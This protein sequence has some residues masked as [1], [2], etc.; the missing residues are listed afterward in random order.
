[1][2]KMVFGKAK[3]FKK[4]WIVYFLLFILLYFCELMIPKVLSQFIDSITQRHARF[5]LEKYIGIMVLLTLIL[6]ISS[7]YQRKASSKI[8]LK[9][10]H[11]LL[12]EV[13]AVLEQKNYLEV[14][15]MNPSYLNNRLFNDIITVVEFT[16]ND[17]MTAMIKI[18]ST[19]VIILWIAFIQY[20][21]LFIVLFAMLINIIGIFT[22]NKLVYER[23]YQYREI[24]NQYH[25]ENFERLA[26]I[27]ETKIHGWQDQSQLGLDKAFEKLLNQNCKLIKVLAG[28]DNVSVLS[29]HLALILTMILG[30]KLLIDAVITIGEFVLVITYLNMILSYGAYFMKLN[31]SYQHSKICYDRLMEFY[32]LE[33]EPKGNLEISK[34]EEIVLEGLTFGYPDQEPLFK[35]YNVTFQKGKIYGIKGRNGEG[36]STFIDVLIGLHKYEGHIYY[37]QTSL[38]LI[39]QLHMRKEHIS[40]VLQEPKLQKGSVIDNLNRGITFKDDGFEGY[41]KQFSIS[42]LLSFESAETLSGGEKQKVALMRSFLKKSEVLILDEPTSALDQ[43]GIHQL[44]E[45]LL[46]LKLSK[47]V[48]LVSHDEKLNEIMD[49]IHELC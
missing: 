16:M 41:C 25:T 18:A 3:H 39:N 11:L 35:N 8:E 29:K 1:M 7:Y 31:Q 15:K 22:F 27:K 23:G 47:I 21:L 10:N 46:E 28:L 38:H 19:A 20:K 36:K 45:L 42:H 43:R 6:V 37:N 49:E 32:Q 13:G 4:E 14:S 26:N 48:I 44:K 2:F 9:L 5:L 40:I 12:G 33:D 24:H 17:F 30:G 34:I